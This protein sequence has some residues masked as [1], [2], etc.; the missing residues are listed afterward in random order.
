MPRKRT[1]EF[2]ASSGNVFAD[3]GLANPEELAAKAALAQM[4]IDTIQ[5]KELTQ[6]RA[7]TILNIDQPRVSSLMKG[8]LSL[9]S[10]EKLMSFVRLLGSSVEIR[11]KPEAVA[12]LT[13]ARETTNLLQGGSRA[14]IK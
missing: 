14:E 12:H 6:A 2:E 4:I 8:R 9:F 11:V 13:V 3:L 10:L 5:E 1:T 7:A